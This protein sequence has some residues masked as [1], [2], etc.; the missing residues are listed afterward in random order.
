MSPNRVIELDNICSDNDLLPD[1]AKPG[2]ESML[3]NG[4][5][6]LGSRVRAGCNLSEEISLKVGVHQGSCLSPLLFITVQNSSL[7]EFHTTC[8]WENLYIQIFNVNWHF[9]FWYC[10][11][12]IWPRKSKVKVIVQSHI[13]GPTFY[14]L[15]SLNHLMSFGPPIPEVQLFQILTRKIHG[16]GHRSRLQLV[17]HQF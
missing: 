4:Q 1:G 13:V 15:R 9:K 16:Q 6:G 11:F 7:K 12:K 10:C 5:W 3:I 14:Q 17:Q 8:S 2:P